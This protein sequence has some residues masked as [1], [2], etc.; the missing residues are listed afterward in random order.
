MNKSVVMKINIIDKLFSPQSAVEIWRMVFAKQWEY[1]GS[2]NQKLFSIYLSKF[3]SK[4]LIYNR[5]K[6]VIWIMK[7]GHV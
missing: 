5:Y 7:D 3:L 4:F 1:T 6:S 2:I